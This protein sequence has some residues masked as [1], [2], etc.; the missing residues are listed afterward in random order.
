[1]SGLAIITLLLLVLA[2][3]CFIIA[4]FA[5]ERLGRVNLIAL[6]LAF[7]VTTLLLSALVSS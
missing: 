6:G 1:M 7:W 4:A 2:L 5:P 3:V